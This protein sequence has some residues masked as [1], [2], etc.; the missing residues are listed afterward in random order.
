M[1]VSEKAKKCEYG[2]TQPHA[3]LNEKRHRPQMK[4]IFVHVE[5][6][7]GSAGKREG[8]KSR[9]AHGTRNLNRITRMNAESNPSE[10]MKS[11]TDDLLAENAY[12]RRKRV[13]HAIEEDWFGSIGFSVNW[14]S[15]A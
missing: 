8:V 10:K 15:F 11:K 3:S 12:N 2:G 5:R 6:G 1:A 14:R 13:S 4:P 9:E 7:C